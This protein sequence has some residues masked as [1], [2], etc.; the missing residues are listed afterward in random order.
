MIGSCPSTH[1]PRR[2]FARALSVV[3]VSAGLIVGATA[4]AAHA[5]G[6][7]T[8]GCFV[9]TPTTGITTQTV[10]AYN[11]CPD[12]HG[13]EVYAMWPTPLGSRTLGEGC[14]QV[15]PHTT[16]AYKWPKGRKFAHTDLC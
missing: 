6:S 3:A 15:A 4:S 14:V 7:Y 5:S 2:R 1:A 8:Q 11:T 16:G 9:I 12:T 13:F 10:Y